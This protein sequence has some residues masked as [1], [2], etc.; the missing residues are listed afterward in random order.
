MKQIKEI[1]TKTDENISCQIIDLYCRWR[2]T[3][4]KLYLCNIS[5]S[6]LQA[7]VRSPSK[8]N[9]QHRHKHVHSGDCDLHDCESHQSEQ[10]WT[11]P[12]DAPTWETEHTY[13]NH[14]LRSLMNLMWSIDQC[15]VFEL[16]QPI[17]PFAWNSNKVYTAQFP[18]ILKAQHALRKCFR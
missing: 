10:S 5:I 14:S 17:S 18:R 7:F 13:I 9:K 4:Q 6:P 3:K 16:L 1:F 8:A 12:S 2:Q 11:T 15:C